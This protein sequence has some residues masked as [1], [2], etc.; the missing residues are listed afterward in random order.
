[1]EILFRQRQDSES[2]LNSSARANELRTEA[3][4]KIIP[5]SF[6]VSTELRHN[7][8]STPT[9]KLADLLSVTLEMQLD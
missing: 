6:K 7:D 2:K 8:E 5:L 9:T 1:M 3:A 4:A